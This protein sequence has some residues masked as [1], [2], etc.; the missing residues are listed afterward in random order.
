M[1]EEL[2]LYYLVSL[3]YENKMTVSLFQVYNWTPKAFTEEALNDTSNSH[4]Q[5]AKRK[6][7]DRLHEDYVGITCE[8]EVGFFLYEYIY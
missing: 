2:C 5:E 7:G 8:G 4:A 3:P 1:L 6:L